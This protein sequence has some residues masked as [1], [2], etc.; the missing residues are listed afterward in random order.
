MIGLL[1]RVFGANLWR[2]S[3]SVQ[4]LDQGMFLSRTLA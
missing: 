1:I 3:L 4:F 2:Q